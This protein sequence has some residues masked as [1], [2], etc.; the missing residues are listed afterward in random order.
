LNKSQTF[1]AEQVARRHFV[2]IGPFP[3]VT[4]LLNILGT[5][6]KQSD[7]LLRKL[8]LP[9]MQNYKMAIESEGMLL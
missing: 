5:I 1:P 6:L 8:N 3:K 9:G 4:L 7:W 2:S